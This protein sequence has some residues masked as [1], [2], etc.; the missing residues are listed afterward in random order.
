MPNILQHDSEA[1][2]G[3][4]LSCLP[5]LIALAAPLMDLVK[6]EKRL[7]RNRPRRFLYKKNQ[8]SR[9][10]DTQTVPRIGPRKSGS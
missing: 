4:P 5:A 6:T 1:V 10:Y 9:D 8:F 2:K 7:E 3:K